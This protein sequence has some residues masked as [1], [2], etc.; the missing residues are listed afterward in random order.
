[1]L[2]QLCLGHPPTPTLCHPLVSC[3][4]MVYCLRR[5]PPPGHTIDTIGGFGGGAHDAL[6]TRRTVHGKGRAEGCYVPPSEIESASGHR[7]SQ[8]PPLRRGPPQPVWGVH[9]DAVGQQ[10]GRLPSSVWTRNR[11][12]KHGQSGSSASRTYQGKGMG[13]REVKIGQAGGRRAPK[14][15]NPIRHA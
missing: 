3:V 1:M 12:V 5:T 10:P 14:K 13:R 2:T 7:G 9:L 6:A 8:K 11:A 15:A 4:G